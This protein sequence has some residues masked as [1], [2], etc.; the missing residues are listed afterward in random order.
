MK[1]LDEIRRILREHKAEL[2]VKYGVRRIAVFGS[3]VRGEATPE[4]D[5]DLLVEFTTPP[6]F[7]KFLELERYLSELLGV[8]VELVTRDA[9]KP[10][11]GER[12]LQEIVEV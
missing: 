6:G 11:I 9:L 1:R 4:S 3:Y 2:A 7:L 8:K 10:H 5:L 12:I